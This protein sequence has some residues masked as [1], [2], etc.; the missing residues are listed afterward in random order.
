MKTTKR[1]N[2]AAVEP[3]VK[4]AIGWVIIGDHAGT[5]FFYTGWWFSREQAIREHCNDRFIIPS[6]RAR[7]VSEAWEICK[8]RGDKAVKVRIELA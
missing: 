5:P 1:K 4:P 2:G 6:P 8:K 7:T 3:I